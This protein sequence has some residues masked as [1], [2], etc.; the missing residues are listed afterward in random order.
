MRILCFAA[1]L[2]LAAG[3]IAMSQAPADLLIR[4]A[5]VVHGDGRVTPRAT[6]TVRGALIAGVEPAA[7]DH[8]AANP[9][10][11]RVID[12]AGRTLVPGLIDAHVHAEPWT[13]AVFLKYGVTTVRDL[14]SDAGVIFPMANEDAAGRPRIITSGPLID[15][16]GSFWKNSVQVGSVGEARAAVRAQV[17]AGARVI[18][19]YTRLQPSMIAVIAAEAR[20]RGVPVAAH[21]GRT[22]AVQAAER[23]KPDLVVMD[24]VL[25]GEMDGITASEQI[26]DLVSIPVVYLTAYADQTTLDKAKE[27]EPYGYV[28]KPIKDEKELSGTLEV[29]LYKHAIEK[30]LREH[31]AWLTTILRSIADAVIATDFDGRVMFM[32][33]IAGELTRRRPRPSST[34]RLLSASRRWSC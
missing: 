17:D 19:V 6:V 23:L 29:A 20:A 9:P 25:R 31:D 18:K 7:Q 4:N 22:T 3:A 28:L 27:S 12:A 13:A 32:N 16:P 15:G 1:A 11:R 14:H 30:R 2:G 26:W 21:L 24:I 10:A 8:P 5:R 34:R 33:A